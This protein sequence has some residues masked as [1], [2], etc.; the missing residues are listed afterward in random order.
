MYRKGY[1]L[2]FA[3]GWMP[4]DSGAQDHAAYLQKYLGI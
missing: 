4:K 2:V 1:D 3:D